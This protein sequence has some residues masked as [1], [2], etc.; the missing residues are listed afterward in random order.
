MITVHSKALDKEISVDREI[1]RFGTSHQ[2]P[3]VIFFGGIHGNEP[4]GVFALHRVFNSLGKEKP[5]VRGLVIGL[6]GNMAALARSERYIERDLNRLWS[7]E[8]IDLLRNG[9]LNGQSQVP[10]VVEQMDIF[11]TIQRIFREE[12]GPYF[13]IDLHTTSA[14]SPPFITLNDNLRNR[15]FAT[16]IPVPIILGIEEFLS[17]PLMSYINELGHIALG[18][19]AGS[20]DEAHS[21]DNHESCIWLML[22]ATG[23]LHKAEIPFFQA[24]YDKLAGQSN[25]GKHVF[26]IRFRYHRSAHENFIMR[27]GFV[28]F[29]KIK[30]GEILAENDKG[31]IH[32]CEG[33]R[34]FLPL[35]QKQGED[36]FFI[37]REINPFWLKVSARLRRYN[38]DRLLRFFPGITIDPAQPQRFKIN[39]KIARWK[40]VDLFH[41]LGYRREKTTE[42]YHY[43]IRRKFDTV[44]PESPHNGR[45]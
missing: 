10:D 23:L 20:H 40:V 30:K 17:G 28:N 5:G 8:Q 21:I 3:T 27:P 4:S 26:E 37:I 16:K 15:E 18:F 24:H 33:G 11:H 38:V 32:A 6:S 45:S 13:F 7:R 29:Q 44:A 36:G 41:L 22:K 25:D 43:F 31:A 12:Q 19:E 1:G 42:R 39:R 34:I 35:Y 2:G 9:G 14:P